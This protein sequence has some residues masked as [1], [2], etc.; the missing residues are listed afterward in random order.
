[1]R[2]QSRGLMYRADPMQNTESNTES[3]SRGRAIYLAVVLA[4]AFGI[5]A[6]VLV[7]VDNA[8]NKA[9][10]A[11]GGVRLTAEEQHGRV[12]FSDS[13]AFCH[14]LN[15]TNSVGRTG[16]NLDIRVGKEITTEAARRAFV[17]STIAE[18]RA[19]GL[20]NMPANLYQ[21]REAESV[22]DF[23]AAVAGH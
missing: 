23:V 5:V 18:G 17:L 20:G 12:L 7:L 11:P 1:M 9:A 3:K 22:A 2:P 19:L 10:T 15:A 21:G 14:T 4:F 16:P 13:C 8:N 6:S